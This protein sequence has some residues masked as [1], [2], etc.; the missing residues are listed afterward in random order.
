MTS[1]STVKSFRLFNVIEDFNREGLTI[2]TDFSLP[3]IRLS[4]HWIKLLNGEASRDK[5]AVI[6]GPSTSVVYWTPG[7]RR[8]VSTCCLFNRATPNKMPT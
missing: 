8:A 4:A 1:F 3:A 7:Q 6:M 2:E 5:S